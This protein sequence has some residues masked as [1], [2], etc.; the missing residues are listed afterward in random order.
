MKIVIDMQPCQT[1]SRFRGVGRYTH[2][3]TKALLM[4]DKVNEY[5]LIINQSLGHIEKIKQDFLQYLPEKN[6]HTW[7]QYS[8][9]SA[10][11]TPG[12]EIFVSEL[13]R[14]ALIERIDPDLVFMP[15]FQEGWDDG[16]VTSINKLNRKTKRLYLTTLHDIIPL[17]FEDEY[18]AKHNPIRPWYFEKLD[19]AKNA[20]KVITDSYASLSEIETH[21]NIK[22]MTVVPLGIDADDFSNADIIS[23]EEIK[24]RFHID[25]EFIL[26][27]GGVNPHKNIER[28]FSAYAT[29]REIKSKYVIVI[30]G[31]IP[32]FIENLYYLLDKLNIRNNVIFTD[33]VSDAELQSLYTNC[34]L[35]V[36]PSYKEGFGMPPLEAMACGAVTIVADIPVMH[37]VI[38]EL[39]GAFFDPLSVKD[40][41]AKIRFGLEDLAFR[42]RAVEHNAAHIKTMTWQHSAEKLLEVINLLS[43]H[44][45]LQL[46]RSDDVTL[47]ESI[48]D[49]IKNSEFKFSEKELIVL[50]KLLSINIKPSNQNVKVYI[51]ISTMV[52]NDYKTGIQRVVRALSNELLMLLG[53]VEFVYSYPNK[54][55]FWKANVI[56]DSYSCTSTDEIVDFYPGD[57]LIYIDL[58]PAL[59]ISH[60]AINAELRDFGVKVYYVIYDLIPILRPE[61]FVPALSQEFIGWA[62]TTS[63]ADG[64]LCISKAVADEYISWLHNNQPERDSP[65]KVGYFHLGADIQNSLPSRG[66]PDNYDDV[67]AK[68]KNH[69]NFIM[70]GT[71]EPRKGHKQM[72]ACFEKL[73]ARGYDVN[74]LIVGR[75]GWLSE[76]LFNYIEGHS[77]LNKHLFWFDG[78]SD[79]YLDNLYQTSQCLIAASLAEGFGLP[80]IEAA[81][82]EIAIIARDIPVFKEVAGEYAFYFSNDDTD[83]Q[84]KDFEN[85]IKLWED[86]THPKSVGMPFLTWRQSAQQ[87]LKCINDNEW[88]AY[89]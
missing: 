8:G 87:F 52:H 70:V 9:V 3:I 53:N 85:W 73:W 6:I 29:L 68:L 75:R 83:E 39:D 59:A 15:N 37:E 81:R 23:S 4:L 2:S 21:L 63:Y 49:A 55:E 22:D 45:Q 32:D 14:E 1:T 61:S 89:Q 10:Y 50:A 51:D 78:V 48:V 31:K 38:G 5:H 36:F 84:V 58:H 69:L 43:Q 26:Y 54:K 28:L 19:L 34:S 60:R 25:K 17:I 64:V 41:A 79:E 24:Q 62:T 57:S 27:T 77:E 18:L 44:E 35:F 72:L 65:L 80:L 12:K 74:L 20:T 56:N 82:H 40:I 46:Q 86:Q 76:D 67:M 47:I 33:Y 30:A 88:Y 42:A 7:V 16:A 71:L 13:L 66:L 11:K